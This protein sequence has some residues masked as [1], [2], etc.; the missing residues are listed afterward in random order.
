M[1]F[2]DKKNH[3]G[4]RNLSDPYARV[5][6]A[7]CRLAEIAET[8]TRWVAH[9]MFPF[10]SAVGIAVIPAFYFMWSIERSISSMDE[11]MQTMRQAIA[12][13]SR[14]VHSLTAQVSEIGQS[15]GSIARDVNG[16][17][18]NMPRLTEATGAMATD[19]RRIAGELPRLNLST[20]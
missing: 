12:A 1:L 16:M 17:T 6:P 13:M 20:E 5:E 8:N 2:A 14:D 3:V 11:H 15:A 18:T 7:V 19:T 4:G 9:F 10:L